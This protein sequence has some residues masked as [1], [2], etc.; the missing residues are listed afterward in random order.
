MRPPNSLGFNA[1]AGPL[2]TVDTL[3]LVGPIL[4]GG[5]RAALFLSSRQLHVVVSLTAVPT[6]LH[7]L[8]HQ[9]RRR[10]EGDREALLAGRQSEAQGDV[11][12]ARA[13]VAERDDIVAAQDVPAE[14]R[15]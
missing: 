14:H 9:T 5:R 4:S 7:E 11:R 8:M 6:G 2:L 3:P 10:R 1:S 15:W 12:F 13:G